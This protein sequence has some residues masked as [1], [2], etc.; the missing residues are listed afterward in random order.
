M[1]L[2]FRL[3]GAGLLFAAI[4]QFDLRH[5]L[6]WG[7]TPPLREGD[8]DRSLSPAALGDDLPPGWR[9]GAA[10][11]VAPGALAA[12][13]WSG[14]DIA[15]DGQLVI[16]SD[17][18]IGVEM[19]P[20]AP[21]QR[22]ARLVRFPLTAIGWPS[23]AEAI[24]I[25]RDRL[26][27]TF[28]GYARLLV[29]DAQVE[30]LEPLPGFADDNRGAEAMFAARNSF[31]VIG[32]DGERALRFAG[33]RFEPVAITGTSLMPTGAARWPGRDD[34]LLLERGISIFGLR[35]TVARLEVAE[36]GLLVSDPQPLGLGI[37]DNAEGIAISAA[38]DDGYHVWLVTDDN[39]RAP[40]RTLLVRYDVPPDGWP[41]G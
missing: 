31:Y 32:E 2:P 9:V 35:A 37:L 29:R 16:L 24:A 1:Q 18:G 17:L 7:W 11:H 30:H 14:L 13:G 15:P 26:V 27:V 19:E 5:D 23:D 39:G 38:A 8:I 36:G 22:R 12:S 3:L 33:G 34:G 10:W 40:Q 28:E 25:D 6:F 41:F 21:D 20:P 4:M